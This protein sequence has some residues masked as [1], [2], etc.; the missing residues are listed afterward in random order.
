MAYGFV[1]FF[2]KEKGK[3]KLIVFNGRR[4]IKIVITIIIV[5]GGRITMR[6][7]LRLIVLKIILTSQS[8]FLLHVVI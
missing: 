8:I 4:I 2:Y 7:T 5:I 6:K 3:L 1:I